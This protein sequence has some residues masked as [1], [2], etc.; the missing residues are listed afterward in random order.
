VAF[1]LH[2]HLVSSVSEDL[3]VL[4]LPEKVQKNLQAIVSIYKKESISGAVDF[5]RSW[6]LSEPSEDQLVAL[7]EFALY[8]L[9]IAPDVAIALEIERLKKFPSKASGTGWSVLSAAYSQQGQNDL[10]VKACHEGLGHDIPLRM[11]I[12]ILGI[13]SK[14]EDVSRYLPSVMQTY[15]SDKDGIDMAT[16]L[17]Q[18][19][20]QYAF[21]VE[22]Q[23]FLVVLKDAYT[24]SPPLATNES[25]R[26]N[27]LW[28][29]DQAINTRVVRQ[30][31]D[32]Q[33]VEG[34]S[35]TKPKPRSRVLKGQ[36]IH[37]GYLSGDFRDHPTSHLMMGAWR[38]HDRS[39]FRI[40]MFDTGW[41]DGSE[42]RKEINRFC[43]EIVPIASLTDE[44]AASL[45]RSY[46]LDVLIELNGPTQAH[47][48]GILRYKPVPI[49]IGYLGWP[50]SYGGDLVDYLVADDYIFPQS[51]VSAIPEKIL[52][53]RGT[54]QINDHKQYGVF[55]N[56]L[57]R[58]KDTQRTSGAFKFGSLNN[59]NKLSLDVWD[60]WMH[61]L[62]ESPES[63]L[64]ILHP[65]MAAIQ[66]IVKITKRYGVSPARLHWMP[67][68][69]QS[70]HLERL[71]SIDLVLDCWPYGGHTTTTDALAAGVP[72][73]A[74]EG[75]N[76]AGRVSGSLLHA[77]GLGRTL[78]APTIADYV[79]TACSLYQNPE[80]MQLIGSFMSEHLAQSDLFDSLART[81]S[82][83]AEIV[84]L[85]DE[86]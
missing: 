49:A 82:L 77:A 27:L 17:Y 42:T 72:V 38:N 35:H 12:N 75:K 3:H 18:L 52:R 56:C 6:L 16:R 34:K 79:S 4:K 60:V 85:V 64:H 78:I 51:Q 76:F 43:D 65:G 9:Y 7:D 37:V 84:R 83:E 21:W 46:E 70:D 54:Y 50:S 45:I 36:K 62:R 55:Q 30:M 80:Q 58:K 86:A 8:L 14:Y 32:R 15:E 74:L 2:I 19:A 41:D 28:C 13:L 10:A 69:N 23:K 63:E 44:C 48:L 20:G 24:R 81:Q 33:Y 68:L 25:P 73:L 1:F 67:K 29:D 39:K 40:T 11:Q 71:D 53:L 57:G 22:A 61:I 5:C 59:I 31:I 66:N 26:T 47:R